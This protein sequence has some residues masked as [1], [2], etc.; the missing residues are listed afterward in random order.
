MLGVF[1]EHQKD[2]LEKSYLYAHRRNHRVDE[3]HFRP[4]TTPATCRTGL[5]ANGQSARGASGARFELQCSSG[6]SCPGTGG[7][8]SVPNQKD[9]GAVVT[10]PPLRQAEAEA[11]PLSRG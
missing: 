8:R 5:N 10:G 3:G 2:P 7:L 1:W 9:A 11:G 4:I 6:A